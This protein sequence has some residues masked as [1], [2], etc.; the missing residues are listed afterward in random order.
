MQVFVNI[1]LVKFGELV[2]FDEFVKIGDRVSS[3]QIFVVCHFSFIRAD[4]SVSLVGY[5]TNFTHSNVFKNDQNTG[6]LLNIVH[7]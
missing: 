5:L 4:V 6:Y 7:V 3:D 1:S 2:K